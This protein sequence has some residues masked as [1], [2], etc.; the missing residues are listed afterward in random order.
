MTKS[1]SFLQFQRTVNFVSLI[2]TD[3]IAAFC[4]V[5]PA[6]LKLLC[7]RLKSVKSVTDTNP[8]TWTFSSRN[9]QSATQNAALNV[10]SAV[11]FLPV[12][13]IL[14]SRA[15]NRWRAYFWKTMIFFNMEWVVYESDF[16]LPST[17]DRLKQI[18]SV[19]PGRPNRTVRPSLSLPGRTRRNL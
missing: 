13:L 9:R 1:I 4:R 5:F 7:R 10:S 16:Y 17:L 19:L 6:P 11:Q 3:Q 15:S 12:V 2:P 18:Q 8:L 14:P